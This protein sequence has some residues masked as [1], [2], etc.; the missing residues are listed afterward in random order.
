M[1]CTLNVNIGGIKSNKCHSTRYLGRPITLDDELNWKPQ[2]DLLRKQLSQATGIIGKLQCYLDRKT[3]TNIY[4]AVFFSRALYGILGW[5]YANKTALKPIQTLQNKVLN[6]INKSSWRDRITTDTLFYKHGLLKIADIHKYELGKFMYLY[7]QNSLPEVFQNYLFSLKQ[8]HDHHTTSA[9]KQ[10][11]YIN[12][13]RTN[14]ARS[15]LGFSGAKLRNEIPTQL[16][17]LSF[18]KFKKEYEIFLIEK[19]ND[20]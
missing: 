15:S 4:Y 9:T 20:N 17:I 5:G 7:H 1:P 10:N 18:Y 19:Y 6:I 11:Y 2:L 8:T 13:A 3:L 14:N 12:P 16:K